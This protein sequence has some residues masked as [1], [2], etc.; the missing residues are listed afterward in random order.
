MNYRHNAKNSQEHIRND[1]TVAV[2]GNPNV[3]KSTMFNNLTGMHQHTG[4]WAGK[5]VSNAKGSFS[6]AKNNYTLIDIPGTYSLYAKSYEEEVARD[7]L[8]FGNPDIIIV[9]C[10]ATR[11]ERNLGLVIAC[12]ELT[13]KTLCVVNMMDEA[14][15]KKI[16]IDTEK[17]STLLEIPVVGITS[18]SKSS[19]K[20][21]GEALDALSDT[22]ISK[23]SSYTYLNKTQGELVSKTKSVFEN[24]NT[25]GIDKTWLAVKLLEN[26]PDFV[27]VIKEKLQDKNVCCIDGVFCKCAELSQTSPNFQQCV[28]RQR[29]SECER[30][31]KQTVTYKQN[32]LKR[33]LKIDKVLTSRLWGYPIMILVL[34]FIFYITIRAANYPSSLLSSCFAKLEGYL[35]NMFSHISAPHIIADFFINGVYRVLS[36]V[37]S[38]MLPP[39]AIFFPFFTILEDSGYLPRV[40]YNLD[41]PFKK[42]NACGKQALTMCMG[43]GCNAVGVTGARIIDSPRERLLSILTNCFVPC[44]GRFPAIITLISICLLSFS[45]QKAPM[46]AAIIL[47]SVI[48]V[49]V[50]MTFIVTYILSK[51]LLKGAASSY[52]L[53]LPPYRCPQ[54]SKILLRS[55]FD[56]TLKVLARAVM[57]AAPAGAVIYVITNFSIGGASIASVLSTVLDP[58]GRAMGLDGVILL[59]FILGFPANEIVLPLAVAIYS[60]NGTIYELND[61]MSIKAL[62]EANGWSVITVLSFITFSLFHFPCSTTMLTIKKETG[63]LKWTAIS[64]ILPTLVGMCLCVMI[65]FISR[66][67]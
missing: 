47:G 43:F 1:I 30:I 23:S 10:D 21:I 27:R 40:A 51:T 58:V 54:I 61:L 25:S 6:T 64:F 17:L 46:L 55:L 57:I 49:G 56:R 19:I 16:D 22:D 53:E 65:N 26:D 32:H 15:K 5:T 13:R 63:S 8:C 48:A 41:K 24:I 18:R 28:I 45:H 36:W 33:D 37:I 42:C 66:L 29:I 35:W 3:G 38:V 4:N 9:V 44:N 12:K 20:I 11:L 34:T 67:L 7:Y 52:T 60:S 59:A 31:V 39:M 62:L 14:K 2:A 50:L